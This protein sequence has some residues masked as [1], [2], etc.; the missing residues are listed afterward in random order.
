MTI[1]PVTSV[2]FNKN[3][4][5]L[6][7]EGRKDRETQYHRP[8]YVVNTLRSIPL[9]AILAMS[10]L[11]SSMN[12]YAQQ[13]QEKKIVMSLKANNITPPD[14]FG[15][16]MGCEIDFI[17]TDGNDD[18]AEKL[19]LTF[20]NWR[21]GE[22][23]I[24]GKKTKCKY[25]YTT[26]IDLKNV[27]L[28]KEV[29]KYSNSDDKVTERYFVSGPGSYARSFFFDLNGNSLNTGNFNRKSDNM[30]QE[31][32]KDFYNY[33]ADLLKNSGDMVKFKTTTT[34]IDGDKEADELFDLLTGG[35]Y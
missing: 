8:S 28:L 15:K 23:L 18:T 32:S 9:A 19:E 24:N 35:S 17:S 11:N 4:N 7:F 12:V 22:Q 6:N 29:R 14:I 30:E 5:K 31:I 16:Q 1:R 2:S 13:P 10:P 21:R 3:Y 25:A 34:N 26:V 33:L 27:E 20:V